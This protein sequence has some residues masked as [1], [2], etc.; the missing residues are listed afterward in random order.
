MAIR[1]RFE[2][3][4]RPGIEKGRRGSKGGEAKILVSTFF[5]IFHVEEAKTR[6]IPRKFLLPSCV[7]HFDPLVHRHDA[8]RRDVI[9]CVRLS[10]STM[11]KAVSV[12]DGVEIGRARSH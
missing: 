7:P 3:D 4:S 1:D 2:T 6:E 12:V 10:R 11:R 5:S 8:M 9:R